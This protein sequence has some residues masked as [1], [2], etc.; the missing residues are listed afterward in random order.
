MILF[1]S[2]HIDDAVISAG[3]L[4]RLHAFMGGYGTGP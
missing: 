3:A 1:V 4:S 2:S